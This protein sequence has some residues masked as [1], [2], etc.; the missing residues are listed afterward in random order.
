MSERNGKNQRRSYAP[1]V[2]LLAASI[3]VAAAAKV[4]EVLINNNFGNQYRQL[5]AVAFC[6]IAA[7]CAFLAYRA[8]TG[9][10]SV[11]DSRHPKA[12]TEALVRTYTPEEICAVVDSMNGGRIEFD[13]E[14]NGETT[15]AGAAL[16]TVS[17]ADE[18]YEQLYYVGETETVSA[19]EFCA[20][21][22]KLADG[23]KLRVTQVRSDVPVDDA[24]IARLKEK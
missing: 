22:E 7:L 11:W 15:V 16:R 5:A 18:K 8:L 21:L 23:E 14:K 19:D 2:L 6:V 17:A 20:A 3:A 1:H 24:A 4:C 9:I 10:G 13:I 12:N